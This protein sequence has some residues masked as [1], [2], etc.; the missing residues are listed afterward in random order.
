MVFEKLRQVRRNARERVDLTRLIEDCRQLLT[1][2]GEGNSVALAAQ[3]LDHYERLGNDGVQ[4]FFE[5]L[6][7]EFDPDPAEVLQFAERYAASRSPESLIELARAAESPRQELLRRL[8]RAPGGTG[9]IVRMRAALLARLRHDRKLVA[10]DADFEHLLSSWFNPGFLSLVQVDWRSPAMLLERLIEHEA[11]HEIDGWG[12]LRRRL[13]P[14]RRCF[15]FFHP[16]LPDEPL[17]FVE[18]ALLAQMPEAIAPLLERSMPAAG[19]DPGKFRVA[20]FYSI[21]NCQPGLRG[22]NLGNFLIKRVAQKLQ[23]EFPAIRV[24]CT[25]SPVPSFAA[26]LTRVERLESE[27]LKPVQTRDLAATLAGLRERHPRDLS[28]LHTAQQPADDVEALK[29]LLAFYLV[30][31]SAL[32]GGESAAG[33]DPVARFHLHNGAR[34]ERVNIA[35]DLSRKGLRQSFGIM[36]N[37]LYD[38]DEIEANHAKYTSGEV[39]ASRAVLGLI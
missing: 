14:D 23:Q 5:L 29:Q 9:V 4:Q 37:Y 15:A 32:P 35:A 30:C 24:F 38:L 17:I 10:V 33:A 28:A 31:R 21:S 2:K 36:V 27:R 3:A 34:L 26:W 20:A 7:R 1:A 22:V 39:S 12:D 13:Q 8:N 25:L 11:V 16:M 19:V 6:A 18:V